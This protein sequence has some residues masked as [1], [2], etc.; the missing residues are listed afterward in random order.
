MRKMASVFMVIVLVLS[1]CCQT[2]ARKVAPNSSAG[3]LPAD[4]P[5]AKVKVTQEVILPKPVFTLQEKL[6]I[7]KQK[8]LLDEILKL[9]ATRALERPKNMVACVQEMLAMERSGKCRDKFTHLTPATLAK[10][11][12]EDKRGEFG[13]IGGIL[14]F[15]DEQVVIMSILPGT[16]AERAG[17]K[18]GDLILKINGQEVKDTIEAVKVL[19]G[20]PGT[21]VTL[22]IW[23]QSF[24]KPQEF[25]L[26]RALVHIDSVITKVIEA[27]VGKNKVR[28]GVV[29]ITQ[30]QANTTADFEKAIRKLANKKVN[31][32]AIDLRNNPGGLVGTALEILA[33]FMKAN[34]VAIV[35]KSREKEDVYDANYVA[36]NSDIR[37]FG[38]LRRLKVVILINGGSASASEIFT[39]T[40][41]DW[42]YPVVGE[43]SFGKGVGQEPIKLSDGSIFWLTTFEFLVGNHRTQ[44]RDHGVTPTAEVKNPDHAPG[45]EP[46]DL[47]LEKA[48]ELLSSS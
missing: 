28:V 43:K 27:K 31:K 6:A 47:Q 48:V 7:E 36:A 40:M 18:P 23:R 21:N 16:P 9:Y 5:S 34:D 29:K 45:T 30:F 24:D 41:K 12:L 22:L 8:G 15:K 38:N 14:T 2:R 33:F 4:R 32:I 42:G 1:A 3:G 25:T 17:L 46:K 19:R 10:F 44:I 37:G 35:H 11:D 26:T 39:G 20:E 13:G